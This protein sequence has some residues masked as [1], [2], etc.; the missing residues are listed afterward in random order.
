M[1]QVGG[2]ERLLVST[3][4]VVAARASVLSIITGG[5]KWVEIATHADHQHRA[6]VLAL[7]RVTQKMTQPHCTAQIAL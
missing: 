4:W 2:D 5:G 1:L 3:V 7:R 6:Q